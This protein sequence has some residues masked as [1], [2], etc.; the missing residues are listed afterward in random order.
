[1]SA[2]H[3]HPHENA[4]RS[5]YADPPD[6]VFNEQPGCGGMARPYAVNSAPANFVNDSDFEPQAFR[7]SLAPAWYES[8]MIDLKPGVVRRMH[9]TV[10]IEDSI[11]V[12]GGIDHE[13]DDACTTPCVQSGIASK[14]IE[15][16]FHLAQ[17]P[18]PRSKHIDRLAY[19]GAFYKTPFSDARS[20]GPNLRESVKR[21][22]ATGIRPCT[23]VRTNV[24][25]TD[26]IATDIGSTSKPN[27][28]FG[29]ITVKLRQNN[30]FLRQALSPDDASDTN[31]KIVKSAPV[32]FKVYIAISQIPKIV[33]NVTCFTIDIDDTRIAHLC[34]PYQ[35][36]VADNNTWYSLGVPQIH[37]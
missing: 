31:S 34:V 18:K 13:L 26:N 29:H 2:I 32:E 10:S 7:N 14:P 23:S 15:E 36:V 28:A 37:S 25:M 16:E 27:A 11:C 5:G 21:K 30:N 9:R 12:T 20:Q 1:M 4:G 6:Q 24:S 35:Q 22:S 33:G 19:A 17:D 3:S 8:P